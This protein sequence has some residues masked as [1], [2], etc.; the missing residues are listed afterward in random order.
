MKTN[1]LL[2]KLGIRPIIDARRQGVREELEDYILKIA[3]QFKKLI[4]AEIKHPTG[5]QL[6]IVIP[7]YCIG[8]SSEAARCADEFA[9]ENVQISLSVTNCW[10]YGSETVDQTPNIPKAICGINGTERP[11]AVYLAAACA[12]HD[13]FGDPAF[14]IYGEDVQQK[15]ALEIPQDIAKKVLMFVKAGLAVASMRN[16]SYLSLG[17]CSMGIAGSIVNPYFFNDY[18]NMRT[19]FVDMS[20]IQRRLVQHIYDEA[21]YKKA[22]A[23]VKQYC[24]EGKDYNAQGRQQSLEEKKWAWEVSVKMALIMR[25]LMIGNPKLKEMGFAEE[26]DGHNAL[27]AG[28]Q[29][30]RQWTDFMPNGD[31]A[32]AV[33]NS[34][35]DWNGIRNPYLLATENDS[36]NG[37]SMMLANLLTG[38]PQQFSDVRTYWSPEAVKKATGEQLTGLAKGGVIHLI[39]SG[40]THT[41]ATGAISDKDGMPM[42]K[43]SWETNEAEQLDCLKEIEWCTGL[44]EYFRG[45]GYSTRFYSKAGM[46][47]TML[48][49]NITRGLGPYL[50]IAEGHVVRVGDKIHNIIDMRTNPSWP[51][52]YFVPNTNVNGSNAF[53]SVYDVMNNWGCN[54]TALCYGHIGAQLI[55]LAAML[56]I[57]VAMHNIADKDIFRPKSWVSFGTHNLEAAD[58]RAC[59][60]YGPIYG[61][62]RT[63]TT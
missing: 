17:Y 24:K 50:Q 11:G 31:F 1:R 58:F 3:H 45:G 56:R 38:L 18:F 22:M 55:T 51:T 46:K 54:H 34:T 53:R 41:Q 21:E 42:I 49:L 23:W 61:K 36:L 62:T 48:R 29:G 30:Q 44:L 19:D 9:N 35:Y 12:G 27:L 16:R 10:C 14:S 13:Q 52:T 39:N 43:T 4:Q 25:D 15:N 33:L 40:P 5:E 32:E 63:F 26:A 7:K 28:F 20:E 2:P 57:P 60:N 47:A 59:A 37:A 6:E 8:R